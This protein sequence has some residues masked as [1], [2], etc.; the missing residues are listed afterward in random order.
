MGHTVTVAQAVRINPCAPLHTELIHIL[1]VL[2]ISDAFQPRLS[3]LTASS[4]TCSALGAGSV[5]PL[6]VKLLT[7]HLAECTN[8]FKLRLATD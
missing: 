2:P 1:A 8:A 6:V 4:P 3:R 5:A 7:M